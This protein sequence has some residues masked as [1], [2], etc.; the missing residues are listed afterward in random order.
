MKCR[1]FLVVLIV[2]CCEVMCSWAD[3]ISLRADVWCP[4][5]CAPDSLQPGI[6]IEIAKIVFGRAGHTIDYQILNWARAKLDIKEGKITGIVGM[7]KDAETEPEYVF[8]DNEQ[9]VSQFCYFVRAESNWQFQGISSLTTEVLGVINGYGYYPELDEYIAQ[10]KGTSKVSAVG[11]D[12]ALKPNIQKLLKERLS[13]IVEDKLVME[14]TLKEMGVADKVK[15]AGC[16]DSQDKIH[17]AFSKANPKA[18]EYA[19]ILSDGIAQLRQSGE[20][21]KILAA[22]GVADWK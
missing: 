20:L 17:I 4:Y 1:I 8:G 7:A 12:D 13:V 18:P 15:N 21:Q 5:N 14:Y 2:Y 22:Y 3:V 6:L 19:K 9:A 11:G 16:I 10:N